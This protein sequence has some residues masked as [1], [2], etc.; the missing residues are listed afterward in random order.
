MTVPVPKPRN[1]P[2][3]SVLS[4]DVQYTNAASTLGR[5]SYRIRHIESTGATALSLRREIEFKLKKIACKGPIDDM[6]RYDGES[7]C[8]FEYN[9]ADMD[10]TDTLNER[11]IN[12]IVSIYDNYT[13]VKTAL[14]THGDHIRVHFKTKPKEHAPITPASYRPRISFA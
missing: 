12:E 8:T 7:D 6:D 11:R 14:T 10:I 9:M 3:S 1:R 4:S 5:K 2:P 13:V